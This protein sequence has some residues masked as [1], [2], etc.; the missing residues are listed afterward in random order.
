VNGEAVGFVDLDNGVTSQTEAS[1]ALVFM[2]VNIN[3][4]F[5]I[6]IAYYLIAFLMAEEKVTILSEILR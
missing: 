6:P 1:Q 2:L 3:G 4:N 5:K